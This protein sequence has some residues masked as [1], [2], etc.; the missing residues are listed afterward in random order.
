MQENYKHDFTATEMN[1]FIIFTEKIT[2]F[3]KLVETEGK[4]GVLLIWYSL[5]VLFLDLA[6]VNPYTNNPLYIC[7]TDKRN[8][9]MKTLLGY[10]NVGSFCCLSI[11]FL[12]IGL[13]GAS[14]WETLQ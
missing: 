11:L 9:D 13:L 6:F 1:G 7:N 10:S 12:S 14:G 3:T 2:I 4:S 5:I 8:T